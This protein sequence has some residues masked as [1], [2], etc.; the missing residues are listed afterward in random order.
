VGLNVDDRDRAV[1]LQC[2]LLCY[3]DCTVRFVFSVLQLHEQM[4]AAIKQSRGE[5]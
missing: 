4:V 3:A 2:V 1:G 5:L